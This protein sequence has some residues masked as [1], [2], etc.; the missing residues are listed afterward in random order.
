M[1]KYLVLIYLVLD[2]STL[3]INNNLTIISEV[4]SKTNYL[5]SSL[6][7]SQ[8]I[9]ETKI[10]KLKVKFKNLKSDLK[11]KDNYFK[12]K[13]RILE[14][15]YKRYNIRVEGISGSENEG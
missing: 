3:D 8:N 9:W 15:R 14:D 10:K 12:N 11:E 4:R 1:T 6:E 2:K 7:T 13:L 5:T